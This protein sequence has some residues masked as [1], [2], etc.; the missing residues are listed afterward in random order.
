MKTRD[1][2]PLKVQL[3]LLDRVI[4]RIS[5]LSGSRRY[6][7]R[8]AFE[9]LRRQYDGA[10]KG[11]GTD[12]WLTTKGNADSEIAPAHALLRDRMRSL[13]RDNS[14]AG[15]AVSTLVTHLVG[16]GIRPR[17]D[18][19]DEDKNKRINALFEEWSKIC[20][21]DGRTDYYGQQLLATRLMIEGGESLTLKRPR[22]RQD[23]LKVPLQIQVL[24]GDHIDTARTELAGG[25]GDRVRYGIQYDSIGRRKA[26]W[27]FPEHPGDQSPTFGKSL[28]SVAV[29]A[30]RVLHLFERQRTQSRG[31][32]WGTPAI[33][34]LRDI[35][36]WASA[37]LTRKKLEACMVGIVFDDNAENTTGAITPSTL[38]DKD[39]D[40]VEQFEAGL[41]AF[42]RNGKDIKFN[43]P[44]STSSVYEWNSVMDHRVATGFRVPYELITGDL[45]QVNF[46]SARIGME[47]FRGLVEQTQWLLIIPVFCQPTWD[48]FCEFAWTAGQLDEPTCPVIWD[49]PEFQSVN[50]FQDAQTDLLE[51]RAGFASLQSKMAKRGEDPGKVIA[52]IAEMNALLD[53]KGIVLDSDARRMTKGGQ[54][55]GPV[56]YDPETGDAITTIDAKQPAPA[57]SAGPKPGEKLQ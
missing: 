20:D 30:S 42:A 27:L 5:P 9:S 18:T 17:A 47:D 33:R 12:G 32:P 25:N 19:G 48:W 43:S 6:A 4:A 56:A 46:S 34:A 44:S 51:V 13:V 38:V 1:V 21:A 37:E 35:D 53:A 52:E 55:Q 15:K 41:F 57:K 29:D 7:A 24:E 49:P 22:R 50:P 16:T 10:S 14:T 3:T 23:G 26:Y 28:T 40:P 31:V 54:G 36:D 2:A 11:R 45:R 8:V 39:G